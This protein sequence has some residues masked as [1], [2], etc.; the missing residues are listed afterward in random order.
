VLHVSDGVW[1]RQAVDNIGWA[2]LG[3][4][5]VVV[6]A[7]EQR[8]LKGEVF[9]GLDQTLGETPMRYVLNTHTHGDH[10][11]LNRPLAKRYDAQI[12][13]GRT[14]NPGENG[15]WF[16]GER[17]RALLLPTPG[18]HT[19]EDCCV[20]IEPDRVLFVG[21]V[22]GWGLAGPNGALAPG[23]AGHILRTYE[24]LI[25]SGPRPSCRATGRYARRPSCGGGRATSTGSSTR[26]RPAWRPGS[27]R[28]TSAA[29]CRDDKSE[30][31]RGRRC[32]THGRERLRLSSS[33]RGCRG[34]A[35]C[36]AAGIAST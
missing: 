14:V 23:Q 10:T 16:E 15:R 13:N 19:D 8:R 28:R 2:D 35:S 24:R 20:W 26:R 21:D 34:T 32:R 33:R 29:G 31:A 27:P 36:R 17:G 3:G 18:C 25:A 11:A 22:F 7:L 4:S 9:A 12:V 5:A 1:V 30:H 6:D